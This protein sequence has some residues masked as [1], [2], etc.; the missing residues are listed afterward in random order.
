MQHTT[1]V[2]SIRDSKAELWLQV[3]VFDRDALAVRA[4]V[5]MVRSVGHPV[6]LHPSDYDL[7]CVG[8]FD[9]TTGFL[10]AS[11]PYHITSAV[12]LVSHEEQGSL[13]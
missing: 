6:N 13:L 9:R 7:Y 5:D 11:E 2:Y 10:T 4:M 12:H 8:T 3:L 1:K